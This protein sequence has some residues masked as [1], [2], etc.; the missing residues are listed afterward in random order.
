[1]NEPNPTFADSP[2]AE[3]SFPWGCLLGGCL[4]V[5]LLIVIG[6][7]ASFYAGYRLYKSQLDT[8]TSTTPVEIQTVDFSDEE[9]AAVKQRIEDFKKALENGEAPEQLVLTADELNAIISS[10]KELKG[11]FF[12][13][14]ED[15]EIKGEAS[16]PV[17]EVIPLG[18]GRF[19]NGALSLKASLESGVLIVQVE[20]AEVNGKPVPEEFMKGMR[21]QNLAKEAYNDAKAAEFLKKFES[22]TIEDD[23][24]ILTPAKKKPDDLPIDS[25]PSVDGQSK[26]SETRDITQ[27]NDDDATK[28][29]ITG[30]EELTPSNPN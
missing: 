16:F 8:Y 15:G 27:P 21:N 10:E 22:L 28:A 11:K 1:M 26:D 20:D 3:K 6:I 29:E 25:V 13:K 18:K 19:F 23:K 12:I 24:I 30:N 14:I 2:V 5:V 9:V 17:P 4:S 7:S